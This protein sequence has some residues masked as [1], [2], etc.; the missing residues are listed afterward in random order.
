MIIL[1]KYLGI[2][3]IPVIKL[4]VFFRILKGKENKKRFSE[5]YGITSMERPE[6]DVIWIHAA[7]IGEFKSADLL[8]NLLYKN[9]TILVTT[10]TLSAANFASKK[11]ENH[12]EQ[13]FDPRSN[14]QKIFGSRHDH[15]S[16]VLD[17]AELRRWCQQNREAAK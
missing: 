6:G 7:S 17:C 10:T 11:E 16:G 3:L 14:S 12:D 5:R 2:I 1:Y 8:I 15:S 9:Y 4:N 13:G